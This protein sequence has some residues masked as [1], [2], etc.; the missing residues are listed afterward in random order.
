[1]Y[2]LIDFGWECREWWENGNRIVTLDNSGSND[3]STYG[4]I[5]HYRGRDGTQE[6]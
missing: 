6:S 2:C 1:M 3:D 5:F 4:S